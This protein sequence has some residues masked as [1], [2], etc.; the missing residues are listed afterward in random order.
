MGVPLTIDV[1][2]WDLQHGDYIRELEWPCVSVPR[3]GETISFAGCGGGQYV[4]RGIVWD[5][6]ENDVIELIVQV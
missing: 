4:V 2:I 6:C 1:R 5:I 3:I